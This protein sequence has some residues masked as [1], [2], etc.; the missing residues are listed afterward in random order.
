[1]IE[2]YFKALRDD[3]FQKITDYRPGCW[4]HIDKANLED[5]QKVEELTGLSINDITDSLDLYEIP[6]I[7]Q[8]DN[9]ILIFVRYPSE[10][11][12]DM[13]TAL[14]TII[15]T[16]T[17]LITIS[18]QESLLVDT[19]IHSRIKLTTTQKS[20]LLFYI[21]LRITHDFT[22]RIKRVRAS[23]IEQEKKVKNISNQTIVTLTQNEEIL[24]QF[25]SALVPL[26]NVLEAMSSGRYVI[27]YEKDQDLLEDLLIAMKQSEDL[28]RVNIRS[29]RSL[30]DAYQI[31]FTNDVNK[32]IKLLTAI[33]IIFTIPT[34][35]ASIY[36]MNVSLPLE[37]NPYAFLIIMNI[38]VIISIICLVIFIRKR[39][40]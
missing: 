26:R 9:N 3:S 11:L 34:I 12:S 4:L 24:N 37:K 6:R 29:I 28:C 31:F 39:W 32:T 36:G 10:E 14:L 19:I 25:L 22:Q 8:I 38:T 18:P 7:E 2:A 20:K 40:I 5:L 1:M 15:L 30:R 27:V 21:L 17:Y 23:V 13:H 16:P 35:I 33:T